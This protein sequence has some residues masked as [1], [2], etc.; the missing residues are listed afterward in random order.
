MCLPPEYRCEIT[1]FMQMFFCFPFIISPKHLITTE[2]SS[3]GLL[4]SNFLVGGLISI[5]EDGN[6]MLIEIVQMTR[7][8]K[9]IAFCPRKLYDLGTNQSW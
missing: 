2:T 3:L 5:P 4:H 7:L 1:P 8:G 9:G 6:C